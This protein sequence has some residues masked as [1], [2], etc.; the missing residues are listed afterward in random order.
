MTANSKQYA[1]ER[2]TTRERE[3]ERRQQTHGK[4]IYAH[5]YTH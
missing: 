1:E 2:E 3:T 4:H 5:A